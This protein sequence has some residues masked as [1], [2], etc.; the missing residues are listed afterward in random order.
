VSFVKEAISMLR[1]AAN[2]WFE[3]KAPQQGAALAFYSLLSL[4]P[5]LMIAIAIAAFFFD[6][7]TARTQLE[8]QMKGLIGKDGAEATKSLLE[9]AHRPGAGLLATVLGVVTLL[10]GASGVF[11]QLQEALNQIWDVPPRE[12][13]GIGEMVRSRFLS[14]A[15]VL[16]IGFL[17]LASLLLSAGIAA[18]GTYVG[19]RVPGTE[20]W[21]QTA[22]TLASLAIITLLFAA[23]FKVL[24]DTHIPWRDVWMGALLTS[25]LF[26]VGKLLIGLYLGKSGLASAYGTAG[27]LVVLIVWVYY[28]AQILFFGAE[29]A[30]VYAQ[31]HGSRS[32]RNK[33]LPAASSSTN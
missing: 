30:H 16:V 8:D 7:Q 14:F 12:S 27:S 15:M 11:G 28:S 32:G 13:S 10:F 29:L 5:L 2:D 26:T 21:L 17:L 4:A 24:P 18:A 19:D 23:I 20:T 3:D 9:H 33:A 25:L 22:N 6:E 31:R 1:E